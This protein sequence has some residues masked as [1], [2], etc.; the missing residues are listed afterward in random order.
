[1]YLPQPYDLRKR[2]NDDLIQDPGGRIDAGNKELG[3]LSG[4]VQEWFRE[5]GMVA[6][7]PQSY[8]VLGPDDGGSVMA[9]V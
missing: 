6:G 4:L 2:Q 8:V 1:M 7:A 9:K 5:L 3:S